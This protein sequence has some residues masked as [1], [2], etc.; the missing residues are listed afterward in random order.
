[1]GANIL[2]PHSGQN[3]TEN[4]GQKGTEENKEVIGDMVLETLLYLPFNH[5]TQL[6]AL[7]Y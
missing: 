2:L 5:L 3:T 6:P 1:M 4:F 7:E